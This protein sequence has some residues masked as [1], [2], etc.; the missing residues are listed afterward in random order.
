MKLYNAYYICK[1][2]IEDL[3]N[4]TVE[5]KKTANRNETTYVLNNWGKIIN[6]LEIISEIV[7]LK[8]NVDKVYYSVP[9]LSRTKEAPVVSASVKNEVIKHIKVLIDKVQVII[10]LYET[11]DEKE[12]DLGVDIKIPKCDSLEEY[13]NC[14]KDINFV[15]TQCP[16]L[17]DQESKLEFRGTD[18][19]S[20]WLTFAVIGTGTLI[21]NNIAKLIDSA[22]KIKSH[23]TTYKQQ[24]E[25]LETMKQKNEIG[26]DVI[27]V[28][29]KMK[30]QCLQECAES[31]EAEL[32][33]LKD[34]DEQGR[35]KKSLEKLSILLDK[36]VQ[37]YSSIDAP[38]EIQAL[39][40][41]VEEN[42]AITEKIMGFLE[43][44]EE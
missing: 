4:I 32:G 23:W 35:L 30:S 39:F 37:I 9:A 20:I 38:K 1:N 21:L 6:S 33:Q 31:V 2:C 12:K 14:L 22:I 27:E 7:Y 16:Y 11:I 8:E 25:M 3:R 5:E 19:G 28:F 18:V 44:K 43:K 13:I 42:K 15:F 41:E 17:I 40:P 26:D 34:G 29:K 24:E 10:D 36:G